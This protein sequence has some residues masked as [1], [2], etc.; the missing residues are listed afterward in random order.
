MNTGQC[1]HTEASSFETRLQNTK[2]DTQETIPTDS[3]VLMS[4]QLKDDS[5]S[6]SDNVIENLKENDYVIMG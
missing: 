6:E 1:L 4:P 2:V 5:V 3:Y